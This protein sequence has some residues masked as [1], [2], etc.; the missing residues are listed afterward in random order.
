MLSLTC[1][2]Y[3]TILHA[4]AI[5][6]RDRRKQL[7]V[8]AR[9]RTW[10]VLHTNND[11]ADICYQQ[12]LPHGRPDGQQITFANTDKYYARNYVINGIA[13]GLCTSWYAVN[14]APRE[15]YTIHQNHIHGEYTAW[16]RDGTMLTHGWY[17][18]G[19]RH[20]EHTLHNFMGP[21]IRNIYD[22]GNLVVKLH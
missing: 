6:D 5:F 1:A 22:H 13:C 10:R 14:S 3:R 16:L 9:F 7:Q 19:K 21:P 20:G 18:F 17:E 11:P 15:R 2:S 8:R 12:T 4:H